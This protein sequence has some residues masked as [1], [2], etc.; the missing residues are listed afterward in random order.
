MADGESIVGV[1]LVLAPFS[2]FRRRVAVRFR[3]AFGSVRVP[4]LTVGRKR[5][6]LAGETALA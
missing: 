5:A 3:S 2:D 6:L 1:W 4:R